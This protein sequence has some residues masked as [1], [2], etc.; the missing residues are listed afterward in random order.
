MTN[1]S[2][3]KRILLPI[4]FVFSLSWAQTTEER[5][6]SGNG[7]YKDGAFE[8]AVEHYLSIEEEG[9]ESAD[10]YFNLGNCYYKMNMVAPSI[11]YFE[12][13]L[14]LDPLHEDA[15]FNLAFAK[16]MTIDIIEEIPKTFLQRFSE[17]VIQKLH[18]DTWAIIAVIASIA[19]KT[20]GTIH[21]SCRPFIF[22]SVIFFVLK[23]RV[24]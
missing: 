16:R 12:K 22:K 21:G 6:S 17:N 3:M 15:Q 10:L 19:T 5:F 20:R 4:L 8:K 1:N 14:K 23:F 11:Y 7:L 9:L 13:A 18:Y 24:F 2:K